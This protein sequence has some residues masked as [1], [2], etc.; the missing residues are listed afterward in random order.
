MAYAK[1]NIDSII[2]ANPDLSVADMTAKAVVDHQA[3]NGCQFE[4]DAAAR[5]VQFLRLDPAGRAG[6]LSEEMRHR[7]GYALEALEINCP[8]RGKPTE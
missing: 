1:I 6:D 3:Q 4:E 2:A 8:H 5:A 7:L